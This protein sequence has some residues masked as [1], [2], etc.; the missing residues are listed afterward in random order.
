VACGHRSLIPAQPNST[1]QET[2][3]FLR[4]LE[5]RERAALG[6]RRS[7]TGLVIPNTIIRGARLAAARRYHKM[8]VFLT[9]T[10]YIF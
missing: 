5:L 1:A 4:A 2:Q 8:C 9:G 3:A 10:N 7:A 6:E